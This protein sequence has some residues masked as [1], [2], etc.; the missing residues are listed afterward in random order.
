MAP[1]L[2]LKNGL[3][4]EIRSREHL[5]PH[6]HVFAGDDEALVAIRSGRIFAG[7]L[8]S[9]KLKLVNKWLETGSNRSIVEENFFELNPRLRSREEKPA[10]S[11]N[12]SIRKKRH[13]E[14][15]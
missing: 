3:R 14:D 7:K 8:E 4:I 9:K 1:L 12:K 2:L 6:I 10:G 5:P 13:E 11:K 15:E